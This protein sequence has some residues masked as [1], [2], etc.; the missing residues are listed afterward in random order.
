MEPAPK[1]CTRPPILTPLPR[2]LNPHFAVLT[3]SLQN[4]L[5]KHSFLCTRILCLSVHAAEEKDSKTL[6]GFYELLLTLTG[7]EGPESFCAAWVSWPGSVCSTW[8]APLKDGSLS[9]LS[10]W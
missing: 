6:S 2:E 10:S 3:S 8:S 1:F 9:H 5:A 7:P 4:R